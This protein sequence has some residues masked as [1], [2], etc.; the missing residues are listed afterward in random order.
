M[1]CYF[2][3]V[4]KISYRAPKNADIF[5]PRGSGKYKAKY[6]LLGITRCLMGRNNSKIQCQCIQFFY[7]FIKLVK[8]NRVNST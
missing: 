1:H 3:Q 6:I 7:N 2:G 8:L 4:E 5:P